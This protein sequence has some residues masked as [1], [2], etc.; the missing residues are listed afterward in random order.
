MFITKK[1]VARRTFL[2]GAGTMLA[3]PLLDA[4]IP[5][6]TALA[7]TAAKP[8]QRFGAIYVPHGAM[9]NKWTPI[10]TGSG[11]KFSPILQ[12]LEPLRDHLVVVSGMM[13][14]PNRTDGGHA[15]APASYLSGHSPKQTESA[16]VQAATTIDQVI[17][18]SIGQTTLF[19]SLEIAT[20]DFSTSVGACEIGFSCVYMN[21]IS[22]QTPTTPLPMETNPR[23]VF[24]RMFGGTG[25]PAQRAARMRG[26]RSILDS[27]M[28]E[29]GGFQAGLG[30]GDRT[31]ISEYLQNIREIERRIERAE[32]QASD[33]VVNLDAPIGSPE[34]Y[35][36]H[37]SVLF[38]LMA[39]AFQADITRVFTFMMARDVSAISFPQI[40]V[41]EPHHALSHEANR[42]DAVK[43]ADFAKVNS[44]HAQMFGRFVSKLKSTK[45]GEGSL[46]D[47]SLV[48]YGSGMSNGNQHSHSPLP[49]LLAGGA[50]GKVKGDR[51]LVQP[52]LTPIGNLH[53]SMAQKF[54]VELD[55]FGNS[56]GRI[57][58]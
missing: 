12:P 5:A 50:A 20:E 10:G 32:Q 48:L 47:H 3:L 33:H 31:R 8:V 35:D 37:V 38:D 53:L 46:L 15:V 17:A 58:L 26:D 19:P 55:T 11:F 51:H 45:E 22:W 23:V 56:A 54:G 24:E 18:K 21:T 13:G 28:G 2:R 25:T 39:A 9:M 44:Y 57:E 14:V 42:G 30:A 7:Q 27:V 41:P 6:S 36:D 40:G 1:S 49:L 43:A 16:D 4:M 34:L 29:L 52:D